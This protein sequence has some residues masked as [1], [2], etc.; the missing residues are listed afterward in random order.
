MSEAQNTADLPPEN[1]DDRPAFPP[2]PNLAIEPGEPWNGRASVIVS[3]GEP[4][5]VRKIAV[6]K[7]DL[8]DQFDL[9][10]MADTSAMN[11]QWL[12]L[13]MAG[14]AVISV[15]GIPLLPVKSKEDIK[16]NLRQIGEDGLRAVNH[17]LNRGFAAPSADASA[18]KN[19]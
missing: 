9:A 2:L 6:V 7:P 15:N 17:A 14:K 11:M 16:R 1:S 5:A 19:S 3:Y 8:G 10:E 12:A 18:A 13:A 4:T